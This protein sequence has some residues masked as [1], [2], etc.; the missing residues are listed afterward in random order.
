MNKQKKKVFVA[1]SGGVDSSVSVALLKKEGYDVTGVFMKVWQPDFLECE[2]GDD[3]LDAMRAAA[4]IGIPFLTF[5]FEKEYKEEVIDYM[6]SEYKKGR[7]PNPDVMCN[8]TIK[9]GAFLKKAKDMGA[10]MIAT[11]H[12]ARTE[13]GIDGQYKLLTG[14]DLNKDQSY[15]LWTLT[16]DQLNRTLFPVGIYNK[17]EVRE[18]ARKF[19]LPNAER[20]ESQGLCFVGKM[21][22]KEFLKHYIKEKRGDVVNEKGEIIGHHDGVFFLTIGQRHGFTITKKTPHDK[23]YYIVGKD[24]GK[25]I[26]TVS[27]KKIEESAAKEV[28]LQDVNWVSGNSP[29]TNK[30]Y[31]ARTRY[32]QPLQKVRYKIQDTPDTRA[33]LGAG[34]ARYKILFENGQ[35][36]VTPGQ[37]LVLYSGEECLGGGII[38]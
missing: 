33:K 20:K 7:T 31:M 11:G 24:I 26:I 5:D 37:S 6:I 17:P 12:Y 9:F 35:E 3:R 36:A 29:N 28:V 23:P 27:H 13:E 14:I 8:K 10:D 34:Q 22:M 16:Q 18:L 32:R 4:H 25:N 15:F 1:M 30:T 21:D 2:R 38:V 19:E